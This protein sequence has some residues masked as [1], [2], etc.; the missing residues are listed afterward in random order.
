MIVETDLR[1][2]CKCCPCSQVVACPSNRVLVSA[3]DSGQK[4]WVVISATN[5]CHF[6]EQSSSNA[7]IHSTHFFRIKIEFMEIANL[8][9]VKE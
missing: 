1:L 2:P 9:I 4:Y 3:R 8:L 5:T 7:F 6:H